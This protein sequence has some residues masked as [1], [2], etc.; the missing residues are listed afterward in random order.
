MRRLVLLSSLVAVL[1]G[2]GGAAAVA[3]APKGDAPR[4]PAVSL[5][6][7]DV[8]PAPGERVVF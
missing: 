1:T 7:S 2:G 6:A 5:R 3:S 4:S 8:A